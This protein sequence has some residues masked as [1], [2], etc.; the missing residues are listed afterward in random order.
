MPSKA[1]NTFNS[2]IG[3]VDQLVD[4]HKRL[5]AGRG[6]RHQQD[7]I[8][9]A[10]VVMSIGAWESY[11]E[12]VLQE[13]IDAMSRNLAAGG[14]TPLWAQL[15]FSIA[16]KDVKTS[17]AQLNTPNSE[18]VQRLFKESIGF[19]PWP[20][21]TWNVP[22]RQWTSV[23]MRSRLNGWLRVRHGI[24][25]GAGLPTDIA[26][27]R[28]ASGQSKLTLKLLKE[29][30]RTIKHLATQTDNALKQF[31]MTHHGIPAPW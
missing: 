21:W 3:K 25:H 19:D 28:D 7:A 23:E 27:I 14:V 15:T 20:A 17:I 29:C 4:I 24:A 31:L 5:Q 2:L 18:N 16:M 26:W 6:R 9:H 22:R 8:H 30:R 13:S 1:M 10:G 11:V 12:S